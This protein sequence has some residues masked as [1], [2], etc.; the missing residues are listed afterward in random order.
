V[1][2]ESVERGDRLSQ[3]IAKAVASGPPPETTED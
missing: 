3:L 1:F 2:D